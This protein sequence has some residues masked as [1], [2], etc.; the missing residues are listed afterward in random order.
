MNR[1][2]A[3]TLTANGIEASSARRRLIDEL[4]TSWSQHAGHERQRAKAGDGQEPDASGL[5]A[6]ASARCASADGA[7]PSTII[8]PAAP[9]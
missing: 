7:G 5:A 8:L 2:W 4:P 1:I 3:S 6:T 9:A